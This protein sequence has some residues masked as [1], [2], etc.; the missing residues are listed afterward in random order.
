MSKIEAV[1]K[2]EFDLEWE[3]N[4]PAPILISTEKN[5]FLILLK[6]E[7]NNNKNEYLVIKF[8]NSIQV[9]FG[10][11]NDEVLSGHRLYKNGLSFY[12]A[13]IVKNS[14]WIEE[15]KQINKVHPRYNEKR[16]ENLKHYI[17]TFV[18]STF[19]SIAEGFCVD[20]FTGTKKEMIN[21]LQVKFLDGIL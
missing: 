14:K 5:T 7:L 10:S 8:L 4:V 6:E 2:I 20:I 16:W 3:P 11:P 1:E 9:K 18:D 19:E 15:I 13:N 12:S 17:F 21:E